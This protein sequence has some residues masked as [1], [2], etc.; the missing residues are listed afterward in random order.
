[1]GLKL[2]LYRMLT[3]V[4]SF[5]EFETAAD[6]KTATEKLDGEDFK[7]STVRCTADVRLPQLSYL[8]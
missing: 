5:V 7:G 2:H 4:H 3:M 6:L 8:L 1:M